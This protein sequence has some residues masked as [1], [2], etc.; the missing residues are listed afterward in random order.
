M[1][2]EHV[3]EN[4]LP[5]IKGIT[6]ISELS[7]NRKMIGYF[8]AEPQYRENPVDQMAQNMKK[9]KDNKPDAPVQKELI[10]F[11]YKIIFGPSLTSD[12]IGS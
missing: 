6:F 5:N 2:T 12:S 10:G 11:N 7:P 9:K 1:K 4:K 3:I 8:A